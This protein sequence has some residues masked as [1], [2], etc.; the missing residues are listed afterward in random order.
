MNDSISSSHGKRNLL[1][2]GAGAIL[3]AVATTCISLWLYRTSGDI[4]LD[5]SRPGYLPDV[6]E[7][8]E[9]S[10]LD[11]NYIFSDTGALTKAELDEYLSE[12]KLITDHIQ[13]VSDPYAPTPLSDE[14]LG[15]SQPSD[16]KEKSPEQPTNSKN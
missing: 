9:D 14:S 7:A 12:L 13:A 3:A 5:R 2:L 8:E 4:Y 15:I 11:D 1:L 16:S 10:D 6:Q